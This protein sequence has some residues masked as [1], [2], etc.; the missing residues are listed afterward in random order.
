MSAAQS[1]KQ[2]LTE[3]YEATSSVKISNYVSERNNWTVEDEVHINKRTK[4][5]EPTDHKT[6]FDI[7]KEQYEQ[8][9]AT[10]ITVA[11]IKD[12]DTSQQ[13]SIDGTVTL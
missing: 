10:T 1:T 4:I 3:K 13:V 5:E 9:V 7:V 8:A 6:D 2:H 12:G 11:E